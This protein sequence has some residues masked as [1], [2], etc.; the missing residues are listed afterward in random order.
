MVK[1]YLSKFLQILFVALP[2]VCG[3]ITQIIVIKFY[4]GHDV[5]VRLPIYN[6]SM[7]A[8]SIIFLGIAYTRSRVKP[9][10][11]STVLI[12]MI[13]WLSLCTIRHLFS[14]GSEFFVVTSILVLSC[15]A[16]IQIHLIR[17]H[18][19]LTYVTVSCII[20]VA[21]PQILWIN[22]VGIYFISLLLSLINMTLAY[23]NTRAVA[24]GVKNTVAQSLYSVFLQ[25]SLLSVTLFDPIIVK[26]IGSG[27]YIDYAVLLKIFNGIF[28]FA[29]SKVQMDI[30]T[31]KAYEI[32]RR[33]YQI[34]LTC[35]VTLIMIFAI[36]SSYIAMAVQCALLA[37]VINIISIFVRIHLLFEEG[38]VK[39]V[40][41]S[42]AAF[43]AHI[44]LVANFLAYGYTLYTYVPIMVMFLVLA[45]WPALSS[46]GE[47]GFLRPR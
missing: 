32:D 40:G 9:G 1:L 25:A 36:S 19:R 42:A 41:Y 23:G 26:I 28:V 5:S 43:A 14:F 7:S 16:L 38:S 3:I 18:S 20:G 35:L 22:E 30:M 2:Q 11:G 12:N 27:A 15:V 21:A 17:G 46:N 24:K 8:V 33:R 6:F 10:F 13:C 45:S 31:M 47:Q 29:F 4:G 34:Y 44:L 39:Y 37:L